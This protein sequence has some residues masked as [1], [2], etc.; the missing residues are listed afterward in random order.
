MDIVGVKS[1]SW[2]QIC[3]VDY[4]CETKTPGAEFHW[5]Q[6]SCLLVRQMHRLSNACDAVPPCFLGQSFKVADG[7]RK[8]ASIPACE[9]VFI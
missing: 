7:G 8:H 9:S 3:Q 4:Q 1:S 6:R 2:R 5:M